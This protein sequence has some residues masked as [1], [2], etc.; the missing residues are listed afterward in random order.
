MTRC[1]HLTSGYCLQLRCF[2][3]DKRTEALLS[4]AHIVTALTN[5]SFL[6]VKTQILN[7]SRTADVWR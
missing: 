4:A 6:I 3:A 2:T 5:N 7:I 1:K